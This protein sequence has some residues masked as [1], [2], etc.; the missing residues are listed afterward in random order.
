[1]ASSALLGVTAAHA[2]TTLLNVSYDVSR[3]LYKD[4]NPAFAAQW[5]RQTGE[6]LTINQSHGGSSKQVQ[7]VV[8]GLEADVVTMNQ[9]PDIDVL[10]RAGLVAGD[11]RKAYPHGATPYTTTT[12]FL[13][14]KGNPKGI[15]DWSDLTRPG[16]QVIVP[17]PKTSGNGRYTY[18]AAWGYAL[19]KTGNEAG[20]RDFVSRLFANVPVLDGGGRGATTTFTQ[21]DVGDVLVTFENEATLIDQEVGG[22]KFD[23]VYPSVSIEAAAPVAVVRKVVDK[24]GSRKAAEAYLN[25]LFSPEGQDII[26]RHH[27]RPRDPQVLKHYARRFPSIR[28]FTVEDALGGWDAVQKVHFADGGVYDQVGVKHR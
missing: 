25:F 16:L 1:M 18:L 11:W 22:D 6:K 15:R 13:V 21:R 28:T 20:A 24:R 8:A 9:A 23:V 3:E 19:Q 2:D 14:R 17:N 26:A 4:I 10:A 7:S 5:Q 12:I 27:F